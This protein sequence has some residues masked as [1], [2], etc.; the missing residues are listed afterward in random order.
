MAFLAVP[1]FYPIIVN[2]MKRKDTKRYDTL[3]KNYVDA[4]RFCERRQ[5]EIDD[6]KRKLDED[7]FNMH[8]TAVVLKG[9]GDLIEWIKGLVEGKVA[10][11]NTLIGLMESNLRSDREEM[12]KCGSILVSEYEENLDVVYVINK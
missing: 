10:M 11:M 6:Y 9:C 2:G 12:E 5:K 3:V 4:R 8:I 7:E 1:Y